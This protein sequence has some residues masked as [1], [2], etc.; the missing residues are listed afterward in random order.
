MVSVSPP[1]RDA[2][3]EGLTNMMVHAKSRYQK[4][5]L[6]GISTTDQ[7]GVPETCLCG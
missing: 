7:G 6:N 3:E 4:Q 5:V 1:I 2:A